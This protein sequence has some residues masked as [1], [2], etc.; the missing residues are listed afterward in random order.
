[1]PDPHLSLSAR[2]SH[3]F[4]THPDQVQAGT[5]EQT[6]CKIQPKKPSKPAVPPV[7]PTGRRKTKR[8]KTKR[9]KPE[10]PVEPAPAAASA[11]K[12]QLLI[13]SGT[14][15]GYVA[16]QLVDSG[17]QM[18]FLSEQFAQKHGIPLQQGPA[19]TM[20]MANGQYQRAAHTTRVRVKLG[21]QQEECTLK[22]MPMPDC[23]A[24]L[25]KP[26]LDRHATRI[27]WASNTI[28]WK[29]AGGNTWSNHIH[30]G[31]GPQR[32]TGPSLEKSSTATTSSG[33]TTATST[34]APSLL[35]EPME[36][37]QIVSTDDY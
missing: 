11:P 26:W 35:D 2:V 17:A 18:D 24:I 1:M 20:K 34:A 7:R 22:V 14:C 10:P 15:D 25:G 4:P 37:A 8:R 21:N 3:R 30:A 28:S 16:W 6:S 5:A 29:P 12:A 27:D 32:I 13:L 9:K 23:D 33:T 36:F 31:M 19:T